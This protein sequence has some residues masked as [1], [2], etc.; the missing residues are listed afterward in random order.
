MT[1]GKGTLDARTNQLDE[2]FGEICSSCQSKGGF[3]PIDLG[4]PIFFGLSLDI[5]MAFFG[6]LS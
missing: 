5:Y 6:Q 3:R 4:I 1:S 2:K